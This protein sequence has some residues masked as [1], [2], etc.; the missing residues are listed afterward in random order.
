MIPDSKPT[1]TRI[2]P[3]RTQ[4]GPGK[5]NSADSELA[6]PGEPTVLRLDRDARWPTAAAT[7]IVPGG[8]RAR[9]G[10]LSRAG[11]AVTVASSRPCLHM[12]WPQEPL[13]RRALAALCIGG[14]PS[15]LVRPID[16]RPS[17][18]QSTA[19]KRTI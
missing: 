9:V 11:T 13:G 1:V 17:D 19:C 7:R 6:V 5:G 10:P 16:F 4:A 12:G 15:R 8:T 14:R 2:R 18:R 3:R